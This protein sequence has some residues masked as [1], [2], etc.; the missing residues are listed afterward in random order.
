M[1]VALSRG[2]TFLS[3]QGSL[4]AASPDPT[5]AA[6]RRLIEDFITMASRPAGQK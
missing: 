3:M 1:T 5:E 2:P 6:D 4:L